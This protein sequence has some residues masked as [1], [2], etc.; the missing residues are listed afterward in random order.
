MCWSLFF[1]KNTFLEEHLRTTASAM[2][3]IWHLLMIPQNKTL[4]Y[5]FFK[6]QVLLPKNLTS[7][8]LLIYFIDNYNQELLFSLK[9]LLTHLFPMHP[10]PIPWKHQKT[11]RF[12]KVSKRRKKDALATNGLN[13]QFRTHFSLYLSFLLMVF[14]DC[15]VQ[16]LWLPRK[17]N[18]YLKFLYSSLSL[19]LYLKKDSGKKFPYENFSEQLFHRTQGKDSFHLYTVLTSFKVAR[20]I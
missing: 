12:S 20:L 9:V 17:T 7:F 11:V 19:Q 6:D 13:K 8:V 16:I 15:R 3:W 14:V 5:L 2:N 10:F 4:A 1:I 18:K